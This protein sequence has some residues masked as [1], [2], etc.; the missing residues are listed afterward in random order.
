MA[1]VGDQY[2]VQVD[3]E[4]SLT[5]VATYLEDEGVAITNTIEGSVV[6]FTAPLDPAAAD[7]LRDEEGVVAVER[8]ERVELSGRQGSPPWNLDRLDQQ[9]LPLNHS[10]SYRV[11]GAGVT[12]YVLDSGIRPTHTEFGARANR[13]AYWDFGDGTRGYDCNGHGT[14]VAGTVGVR[15]GASPSRSTSSRSRPSRA[16][17][18]RG[19]RSSSR[20]STG[21]SATTSLVSRQSST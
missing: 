4:T 7:A 5:E 19:I 14:H 18:A 12:A 10:Y 15:P 16:P 9:F 17:A 20:G 13:W 8:D 1:A 11:T 21:S 3:D 6:G 2:I